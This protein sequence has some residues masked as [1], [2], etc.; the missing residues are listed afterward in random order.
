MRCDRQD[1]MQIFRLAPCA[2]YER[3]NIFLLCIVSVLEGTASA[4]YA[5]FPL[6]FLFVCV[7][8]KKQAVTTQQDIIKK[9]YAMV[10]G[11]CILCCEHILH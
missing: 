4:F 5:S 3:T 6:H 2:L 10:N 8:Q 9:I 7:F 11:V 1:Q